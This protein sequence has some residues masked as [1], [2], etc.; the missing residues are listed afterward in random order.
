MQF[1]DFMLVKKKRFFRLQFIYRVFKMNKKV[2][3]ILI[4]PLY[5]TASIPKLR[6]DVVR[7]LPGFPGQL[8]LF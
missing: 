5:K 7:D 8:E 6:N 4:M 1:Y 3:N 2:K